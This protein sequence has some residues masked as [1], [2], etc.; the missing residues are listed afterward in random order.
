[1]LLFLLFLHVDFLPPK[2]CTPK[3]DLFLKIRSV[4]KID[5]S[6]QNMPAPTSSKKPILLFRNEEVCFYISICME[7]QRVKDE[8]RHPTGLLHPLPITEKKW[9]V[10]TIGFITKLLRKTW[11]RDS[12]MTLVDKLTKDSHFIHVNMIHKQLILQT[13]T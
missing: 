7:C 5:H 9:E 2:A 10:V 11:R 3:I 6:S 8:N 4:P 1:M 13:F 12:I